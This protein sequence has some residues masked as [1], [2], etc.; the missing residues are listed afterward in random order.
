MHIVGQ[1][2]LLL[3]VM[4]RNLCSGC[5]A[6][7]DLCPYFK[8]YKGKTAMLFPCTLTE[9]RCFA[10]CPKTEVDLDELSSE[11]F[12][13]P[14][15]GDPLGHYLSVKASKAGKRFETA[16]FQAGGTVSA[17]MQC[18]LTN[19]YITGAVLTD[20]IGILPSPRLVTNPD[21]VVRCASS[22]Y[23]A[24]PTLSVFNRA[25]KHGFTDLGVVTTPCQATAVA[26]MRLNPTAVADFA[27]PTALVIGLFCTW[28]LDYRA[29]ESFLAA[30]V[31]TERIR[32][33]DIPPPPAEVME[34][35][36]DDSKIEFPLD[37]I[38]KLVPESCS[39]CADM[40][41][42]FSD[43]SV[44]VMEGHQDMNTL[45][46][47]TERGKHLVAE[48]EKTG[49]LVLDDLPEENLGHLRWAARNK[50][51]RG[52]Q[53]AQNHG[54]LNVRDNDGRSYL[55]INPEILAAITR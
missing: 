9:G 47:R 37:E 41:A 32:K 43:V 12:G 48:A 27:D 34:I 22:K 6:C 36:F 5:G 1:R 29:F 55:R 49:F 7:I 45:I 24:S 50:K 39:Y 51:K 4:K 40:T 35:F 30:R 8:S 19:G 53:K 38:R 10:Y 23:T 21:D 52:L 31:D 13:K 44:G 18:A 3:D 46:I 20:R 33:I 28:A 14:Y 25:I 11:L 54:L 2:E 16:S 17:L 26:K 15:N 42:E